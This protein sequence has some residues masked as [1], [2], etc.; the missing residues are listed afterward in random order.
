MDRFL[1]RETLRQASEERTAIP[2]SD[3]V[4][5]LRARGT[6]V[7]EAILMRDLG[8]PGSG[9]RVVDPWEGPQRSLRPL[10]GAPG[11]GV[12]PW[13]FLDDDEDP[14]DPDSPAPAMLRRS[15]VRLGRTLDRRSPRDIARWVAMVEEASRL[16][17]AA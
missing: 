3:L 13:I 5:R 10:F 1:I 2:F 14:P 15:L 17:R 16:P 4:E 6:P 8:T 12:D 11:E 7:T 9:V